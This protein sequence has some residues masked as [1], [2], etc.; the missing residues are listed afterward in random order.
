MKQSLVLGLLLLYCLSSFGTP[1]FADTAEELQVKIEAQQKKIAALE[2]EITE[3]EGKLVEIGKNKTTLQSEV[4]R[5]DTSRKKLGSSIAVTQDKVAAANLEIEKLTSAI[6]SK[7]T[8]I[9]IS[10]RGVEQSFRTLKKYSDLTLIEKYYTAH[11]IVSFWEDTD[12]IAK[13]QRT[14]STQATQ[15]ALSKVALSED[16]T[17]VS[18]KR[19][20]LSSLATQL[21]GQKVVLDQNRTEQATLLTQT[22]QS[23][24]AYQKLLKEK[25]EARLQFEQELSQYESALKYTIDPTSLPT[26]GSGVLSW[27]L[28]PEFMLRCKTRTATFKNEFCLTQYFGHTDFAKSGAYNGAGHNGIDFGSPDGTKVIAAHAGVVEAT[29]NTDQY[30]GCYSYGKWVL[31]K[32]SNGLS[33]LY[34]HLSYVS[35]GKGDE[36]PLGAMIGYTGK[37]GYATGPHLHFT[38]FASDGVK[39]VRLGDIKSKTNCAN[40]TVPVAPTS[41]YLNPMSYL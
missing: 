13:L 4:A 35:V 18:A 27:P 21:K 22:K 17:E 2:K 9:E 28:D 26:V 36:L 29:G 19:S 10:K 16:R 8:S 15:L 24:S 40:A 14:L 30:K 6:G 34:A 7:E 41:A 1:A 33:T 3:F 12:S 25:Q 32:H 20:E 31:I 39:L 23:E 11:G 38:V 37:T 5:L